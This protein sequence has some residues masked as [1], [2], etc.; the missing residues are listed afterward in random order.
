MSWLYRIVGLFPRLV[1]ARRNISRAKARSILAAASILIGVVAIGAIGAGGAA[2]KQSQL[3]NIQDQGATN[4]FVSPGLDMEQ[5][6]F[7]REDLKAID[8]TVGPAGVVATKSKDMEIVKQ[9][10]SREHVSVT[11]LDDPRAM[12]EIGRGELPDNWRRSIVV[13]HDYAIDRGIAPGDRITL[14]PEQDAES[15]AAA[16]ERT[17]RV[18]AVLQETQSFGSSSIYLPIEEAE[19]RHYSQVRIMTR[20]T[21]RAEAVADALRDRFNDRKDKVLVFELTSLVRLLKQ[22]VNGINTFLV[23][24]GS[25]SLLVAGVSITN[26]MLMAVIKRREEI[27]VLRAVGYGK[28]DIVRIL[29]IESALLGILGSAVGVV[30]AAVVAA[31]ANSVFLGNPFAFTPSAFMY[32]VGAVAFGVFT[33]LLAGVYPAWRAANERPIEALRG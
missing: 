30:I 16:T 22:V 7:D 11:Y 1:I 17:Y 8:E 4:V 6:H 27:G 3:Q 32:L 12:Y 29:L 9:N 14:A 18:V 28:G 23:G 5:S 24:L 33:S 31:V 26:T 10:D 19:N 2:F 20:S 21:D 25:I 15:E 13:S